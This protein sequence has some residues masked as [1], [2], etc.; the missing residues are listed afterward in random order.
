M[1]FL[2]SVGNQGFLHPAKSTHTECHAATEERMFF[3]SAYFMVQ[4]RYHVQEKL[5][6]T[7]EIVQKKTI[8]PDVRSPSFQLCTGHEKCFFSC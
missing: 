1:M 8:L 4:S 5:P 3:D 6:E 7:I 2:I